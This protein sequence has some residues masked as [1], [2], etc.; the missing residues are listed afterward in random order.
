MTDIEILCIDDGSTDG[1]P[2]IIRKMAVSDSRIRVFEQKNAGPATA[3]NLGLANASGRYLMF[4]DSDDTYNDNMCETMYREITE[5]DADCVCCRSA[6]VSEG[7]NAER[8]KWEDYGY[9]NNFGLLGIY[10]TDDR[11]VISK[12]NTLL[13]NKIFKRDIVTRFGI[14]F[15]DGYKCEDDA[16]FYQYYAVAE[17]ILFIKDAL[18]NY[19]QR[20]NSSMG[21][22]YAKRSRH[23]FDAVYS[24]KYYYDF[25]LR[26]GINS[27]K[28]FFL[29]LKMLNNAQFLLIDY[30]DDA[31]D[32]EK[33]DSL[34]KEFFPAEYLACVKKTTL[35]HYSLF[36]LLS[37]EIV[38]SFSVR[39]LSLKKSLIVRV[40][41]K[42]LFSVS[43]R[44]GFG[45]IC[46]RKIK[47]SA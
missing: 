47:K 20:E 19:L 26:H 34:L 32:R 41:G 7:I 38:R 23:Y 8:Q 17:R 21:N 44:I 11:K 39:D 24:A 12:V 37:I 33:C 13:W 15:P 35:C 42:K 45:I 40:G 4:C 22:F 18:Y 5:S 27:D 16:F 9:Y 43:K 31:A 2:A 46:S 3:R 25:I 29:C 10:D 30:C 14:S 36:R 28:S 6:L 1:S